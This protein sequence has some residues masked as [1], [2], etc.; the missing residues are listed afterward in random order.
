MKFGNFLSENICKVRNFRE[1]KNGNCT[2]WNA[3]WS[4]IERVITKS[5]HREA[6]MRFVITSLISDQN[7]TTQIAIST[8]FYSIHF[9]TTQRH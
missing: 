3:I 2:D 5:Y 1:I 7:C 9:E 8:L 4:E 6:G